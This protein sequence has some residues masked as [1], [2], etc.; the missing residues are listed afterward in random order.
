MLPVVGLVLLATLVVVVVVGVS[1]GVPVGVLVSEEVDGIA[2]NT[3]KTS[4]TVRILL[5]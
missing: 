4:I 3:S 2:L 1:W 5:S